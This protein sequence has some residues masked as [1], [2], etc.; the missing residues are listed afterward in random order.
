[1]DWIDRVRRCRTQGLSCHRLRDRLGLVHC[2]TVL[3]SEHLQGRPFRCNGNRH[4]A[5]QMNWWSRTRGI[6]FRRRRVGQWLRQF[7]SGI[8]NRGRCSGSIQRGRFDSRWS[9]SNRI[10]DRRAQLRNLADFRT[11]RGDA[12]HIVSRPGWAPITR[13]CIATG[14]ITGMYVGGVESIV[15]SGANSVRNSP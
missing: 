4:R 7:D 1:M 2:D 9:M 3:A 10:G 14:G 11:K 6:L 5:F 15:V 13:N 8:R 12:R